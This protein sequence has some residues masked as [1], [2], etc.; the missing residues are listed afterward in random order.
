MTSIFCM[1]IW[2]GSYDLQSNVIIQR[3]NYIYI[4]NNLGISGIDNYYASFL[5]S[6]VIISFN[7][8]LY[9]AII[10]RIIKDIGK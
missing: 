7:F 8:F 2:H 5:F 9:N 4:I 3:I 6:A 1:I 10:L